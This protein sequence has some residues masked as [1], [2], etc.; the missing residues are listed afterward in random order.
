MSQ[1]YQPSTD[2]PDVD[3]NSEN[4]FGIDPNLLNGNFKKYKTYE[5]NDDDIQLDG[6]G[7]VV[8]NGKVLGNDKI[9]QNGK[10]GNVLDADVL[11]DGDLLDDDED[12]DDYI[13]DQKVFEE[14]S[15]D[16]DDYEDDEEYDD[17]DNNNHDDDYIT[18]IL[19]FIL[20][21]VFKIQKN[22]FK[23]LLYGI[24]FLIN[25][26]IISYLTSS[27]N[28]QYNSNDEI[29][30]NFKSFSDISKTIANLQWQINDLNIKNKNKFHEFRHYLDS[31]IDEFN[32]K[33]TQLDSNVLSITKAN[34]EIIS[35]LDSINLETIGSKYIK[36]DRI[37]IILDDNSNIKI[38]PEFAD[39]LEQKIKNLVNK[40][41]PTLDLKFQ[42]NY[43]KFIEDYVYDIL[44]NKI[45]FMNKDEILSIIQLQFKENK[46]KLISEIKKINS[47]SNIDSNISNEKLIN[48]SPRKINKINY[49][50]AVSGARI[51]NYLTSP[52][53]NQQNSQKS[54][55]SKFF[56]ND[57][58]DDNESNSINSP[59]IILTSNE[60]YWKSSTINNTQLGIKFL[61]P[62][63]LSDI[64]Y[65]HGRFINGGILTSCPQILELY[66]NVENQEELIEKLP[67]TPIFLQNHIKISE[68]NY[69]LNE[70]EEQ[71]FQIPKE[72][73]SFI[74]KSLIIKIP[75]NY[76]DEF[77][78][79]F[80]KLN[81]HGLT[82]FDLYSIQKII[83]DDKIDNVI[84][85]KLNQEN[86]EV[87]YSNDIP[88]FG[89]DPIAF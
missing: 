26:L 3:Q 53:F 13:E 47:K 64:S 37:P 1:P 75:K 41:E 48:K 67:R 61:D 22:W 20:R 28:N 85:K 23:S 70:P 87:D 45:G 79:S 62:I 57:Q 35:R 44:N 42:L 7:T 33:F 71:F 49:G 50:Q 86:N 4:G 88:K 34:E 24:I 14:L 30:T 82:K 55:I 31:K 63:Y 65:L 11:I 17:D 68:L 39:F 36:D 2:I 27:N 10:D 77:F 15:E 8:E 72:L 56:P 78:T 76:G 80:Y 81:I 89:S 60:G 59:F 83:N 21:I 5:K 74:I 66:V 58:D 51:L 6:D 29:L 38:L 69:H 73:Q 16:E 32:N 9:V 46:S 40:Y 12:D 52:T 25:L 43:E 84:K 18:I 19:K 54:F